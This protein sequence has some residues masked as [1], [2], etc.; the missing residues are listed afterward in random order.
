[1]KRVVNLLIDKK[2]TISTMESCTGGALA[3]SISNIEGCSFKLS[4]VKGMVVT[5][6]QAVDISKIMGLII[7]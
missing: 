6:I 7:K 3:N 4:D 5:P 1:M 2:K